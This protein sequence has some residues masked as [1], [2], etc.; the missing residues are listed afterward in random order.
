MGAA[1]IGK[2]VTSNIVVQGRAPFRIV[3]IHSSDARF[4]GKV[5]A[6][7]KTF[8]IVPITFLAKDAKTAPGKVSAKIRIET[9]LAGAKALEVDAAAEV[10]P[11]K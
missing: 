4:E 9:D 11:E 6:A 1:E 7:S 5:P 3:A 10:V 2:P 8:H